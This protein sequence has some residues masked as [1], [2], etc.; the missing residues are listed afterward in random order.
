MKLGDA[1]IEW[2][3]TFKYLGITF[4]SGTTLRVDCQTIKR[5]FYAACNSILCHTNRNNDLVKLH[6]IKSFCLPLLTYCVGAMVIPLYKVK[7]I[8]VCWNDVF[9]TIFGFHRWESVKVLQWYLHELP[10]EFIYD[11]CRWKFLTNRC[12]S[13]S[14]CMLL[15]ISNLQF[16]F[17]SKFAYTYGDDILTKF[18]MVDSIENFFSNSIV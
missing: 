2:V 8:G 15:D 6:L 5:K 11:L 9:R 16:G 10:F 1:S 14:Y 4:I 12:S 13:D 7:S 18:D 3:N 17:L